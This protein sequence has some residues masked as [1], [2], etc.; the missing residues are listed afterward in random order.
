MNNK[1]KIK[2]NELLLNN[3]NFEN[4]FRYKSLSFQNCSQFGDP[5]GI[6]YAPRM[7]SAGF[8]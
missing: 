5:K 2:H 3:E 1:I 4:N 7:K 8:E 6:G